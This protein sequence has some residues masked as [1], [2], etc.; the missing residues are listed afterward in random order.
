MNIDE[1]KKL[2]RA[3]L[4]RLVLLS[5]ASSALAIVASSIADW[6]YS[7]HGWQSE[8]VG[9]TFSLLFG[10]LGLVALIFIIMVYSWFSSYK[11]AKSDAVHFDLEQL[12]KFRSDVIGPIP[13]K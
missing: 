7:S 6:A 1:F 11:A 5:L 2:A 3:N 9:F 4:I 8:L 13:W 12:R 10:L